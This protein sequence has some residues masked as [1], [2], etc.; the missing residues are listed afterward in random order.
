MTGSFVELVDLASERL[1]GAVVAAND[2]FFAA[3]ENL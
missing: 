2:E 3:K 1:G